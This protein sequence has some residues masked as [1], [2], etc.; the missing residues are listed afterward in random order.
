MAVA[1]VRVADRPPERDL[2]DRALSHR[3]GDRRPGRRRRCP[4][5]KRSGR[6]TVK[7][8]SATPIVNQT[9]AAIT[10]F[11]P[12]LRFAAPPCRCC[13]S[14]PARRRGARLAQLLLGAVAARRRPVPTLGGLAIGPWALAAPPSRR[15]GP[16]CASGS[17]SRRAG[18]AAEPPARGGSGR[19]P[20]TCG[21]AGPVRRVGPARAPARPGA[22]VPACG[23]L[24]VDPG[25]HVLLR[26]RRAPAPIWS[27]IRSRRRAVGRL[28]LLPVGQHRRRDEDRRVGTRER[29]R[30]SSR[31][32][33]P[34]GWRRRR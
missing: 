25:D 19:T 4:P 20:G 1:E 29:P 10:R 31:R 17:G 12:C 16:A 34:S 8:Q 33:S 18:P 9:S 13:G 26:E 21:S 23:L 30:P 22:G 32:R 5:Q 6:K 15:L 3:A 11:L 7:C 28:A 27:S 24:V 2:D 14:S